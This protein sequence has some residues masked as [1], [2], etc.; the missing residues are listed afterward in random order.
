MLTNVATL[1]KTAL[2]VIAFTLFV[3]IAKGQT[4]YAEPSLHPSP[5]MQ[6][7]KKEQRKA[8]RAE[9]KIHKKSEKEM[10]AE[11][12]QYHDK[13]HY[14]GEFSHKKYKKAKEA[15]AEAKKGGG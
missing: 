6:K 2:V 15:Q 4:Q 3:S 9:D 11:V 7:S 1:L 8:N 5:Q 10:Q 12:N 13:K 14:K